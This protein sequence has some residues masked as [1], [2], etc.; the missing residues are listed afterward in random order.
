MLGSG[1]SRREGSQGGLKE[2]KLIIIAYKLE[3]IILTCYITDNLH[4][5]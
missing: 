5:I 2:Q 4:L 1:E 3:C